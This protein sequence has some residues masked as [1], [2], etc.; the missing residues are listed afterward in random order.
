MEPNTDDK[1]NSGRFHTQTFAKAD[2]KRREKLLATAL[3]QFA[4]KGFSA[5]SVN[6]IARGAGISIGALYS[7]FPS[8]D[9]LY[10]TV[11]EQGRALLEEALGDIDAAAPFFASYETL[12]RRAR[13]YALANPELNRIYLDATTHGLRHLSR[14][15]SGSLETITAEMYRKILAAAIERGEVRAGTDTGA[16]A[17]CLD[18]IM[19]LFQFSF[20]SDYYQERLR[21]F[22]GL[23][24]DEPIDEEAL[25]ASITNFVRRALAPSGACP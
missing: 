2:V 1:P 15:L 17:F 5:T 21:I 12:V 24:G 19:V 10:L 18:S 8:K 6:D 4:E 22:L 13:D 25:I 11:V 14:R 16:D 9:D 3:A 20:A 23:S 7:Y